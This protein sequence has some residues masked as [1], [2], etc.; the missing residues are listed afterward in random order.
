MSLRDQ[1]LYTLVFVPSGDRMVKLVENATISYDGDERYVRVLEGKAGEE[2]SSALYGEFGVLG[3]VG[4]VWS[5]VGGCCGVWN[6]RED[7]KRRRDKAEENAVCRPRVGTRSLP[8]FSSFI[9]GPEA[10]ASRQ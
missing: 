1:A 8:L 6:E 5:G 4:A 9:P 10:P 2:Y 3:G 7:W